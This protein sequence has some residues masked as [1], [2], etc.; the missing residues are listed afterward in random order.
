M[1]ISIG[2]WL[3]NFLLNLFEIILYVFFW[4]EFVGFMLLFG[5]FRCIWLIGIVVV[6]NIIKFNNIVVSVLLVINLDYGVL[7]FFL[8]LDCNLFILMCLWKMLINVGNKVSVLNIVNIILIV[9]VNFI[10]VK[11]FMLISDKL[12]MVIIIVILVKM[13]VLFVVFIVSLIFLI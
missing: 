10:I 8:K 9:E 6:I 13:I 1:L 2:I 12:Y 5:M 4:V 3:L 7:I 11:K